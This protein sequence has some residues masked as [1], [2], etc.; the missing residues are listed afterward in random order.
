[1]RNR[2]NVLLPNE[3]V[4]FDE[5]VGRHVDGAF[6]GVLER[7][8]TV[9]S[10]TAVD[11]FEDSVDGRGVSIAC[12]KPEE[13]TSCKLREGAFGPE[14]SNAKRLLNGKTGAHDLTK[15][16][17]NR[18]GRKSLAPFRDEPLEHR[19]LA[20]GIM[21]DRKIGLS[22]RN[23]DVARNARPL[24]KKIKNAIVERVDLLSRVREPR[25]VDPRR[26]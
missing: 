11:R 23:R 1:V 9:S 18:V 20:L 7:H 8:D 10:I 2:Q 21:K 19:L 16:S 26:R 24:G 4:A 6:G 15:D 3:E 13:M 14:V 17:A 12:L 25:N 5:R 22:L